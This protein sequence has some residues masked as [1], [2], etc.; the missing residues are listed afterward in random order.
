VGGSRE[1]L[2]GSLDFGLGQARKAEPGSGKWRPRQCERRTGVEQHPALSR[3]PR[4]LNH[5]LTSAGTDP[6]RRSAGGLGEPDEIAKLSTKPDRKR[7]Q[8]RAIDPPHSADVPLNQSV[9]EQFGNRGL[10]NVIA[11]EVHV[12]SIGDDVIDQVGRRRDEAKPETR[13][14]HLGEGAHI[15]DNSGAIDAGQGEDWRAAV[16]EFVIVV[17]FDHREARASGELQ[18]FEP[19]RAGQRDGRRELM[20]RGDVDR[21][22]RAA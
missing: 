19:A 18:Q 14:Q 16:M 8:P 11:M 17:V 5:R 21:S 20:V 13:R 6:D 12:G 4:P 10:E 7:L 1:R 2:H 15:H 3:R 22:N 9:L